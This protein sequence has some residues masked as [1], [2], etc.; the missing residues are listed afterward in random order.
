MERLKQMNPFA[1][2]DAHGPNSVL[3]YKVLTIL[4]WLLSVV[5]SFYYSYERPHDGPRHRSRIWDQ[6][7]LHP[8]AFTM[9]HVIVSL[10]WIVLFLLQLLGYIS[11]LFSADA[12]KVNAASSVGSHFVLNNLLHFAFVM[13]FVRSFFWWAEV[14]L[15][16]NFINLTALHWHHNSYARLIHLPA[17]AGP[18]AWTFVALFWNGAI[19]VNSHTVVARIFANIMIWAFLLYGGFFLVA[20][21]DYSM[22]L[23]L[24]VLVAAI[25]VGQFV[26][27]LVALQWIFAF[28]I[29]AVLFLG[30]LAIAVPMWMGK[31][32]KFRRSGAG[33]DAERAPLLAEN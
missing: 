11:H 24:S 30:S 4:S 2:R 9:N 14:M 25:G 10:Y 13:L 20:Y 23:C 22:G 32:V 17:V 15:V 26:N 18:L 27:K 21:K 12:A 16:L 6:N 29:M 5:V 7:S 3:T 33:P 28:T 8:T 31:E 1:K 19:M